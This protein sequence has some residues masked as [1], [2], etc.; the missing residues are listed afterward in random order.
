MVYV[1]IARIHVNTVTKDK[2]EISTKVGVTLSKYCESLFSKFGK[3][4]TNWK[5]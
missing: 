3:F 2:L 5:S 4:S 1:F